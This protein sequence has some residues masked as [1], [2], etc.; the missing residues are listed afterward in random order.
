[1]L[2]GCASAREPMGTQR[3]RKTSHAG[4]IDPNKGARL[5]KDALARA[6][7]APR[8]KGAQ[9]AQRASEAHAATEWSART[10][11]VLHQLIDGTDE[12]LTVVDLDGRFTFV[13]PAALR[14]FGLSESECLG[15]P[16]F[17]FVFA[18]DR[19]RTQ[20]AFGDWVRRRLSASITFE[21]RQVGRGGEVRHLAWNILPLRSPGGELQGFA[22]FARDITEVRAAEAELQ[23]AESGLRAV[24]DTMLDALISIDLDGTIRSASESVERVL[25]YAR[26]EMIGQNIKILM[27]EP[28]RSAHDA[29]LANYRRTRKTWI[30]GQTRDF[31]VVK[32]DASRIVCSLAVSRTK[33]A[34]GEDEV[35]TGVFRDVTE[36]RRA[37]NALRESELRFH[38][39]FDHA[40]QYLGL[41]TPDGRMLEANQTALEATGVKREDVIGKYFWETRWWSHSK[42]SQALLKSA[43]QAASAGEF[44]RFE[45][46]HAGPEDSVIDVD[47]SIKPVKDAKGAVVLLIP[48]G[49][50]ITAIKRAQRT[51][52]AMLRAMATIGES[53]A[54][55]AH[56]IKNPIT[57]VNL[58][59]RAVADQ[60]GEDHKAI[61]EDL[62]LRMQRLEQLM[63]R[64]LSFA[65]PI[66][67]RLAKLDAKSLFGEVAGTLE[68]ELAKH[69]ADVSIDV[70]PS[71]LSFAGDRQLL[72]EVLS[73]LI[74]NALEAKENGAS[75]ILSARKEH[76]DVL[77]SV[78]DDGPGIPDSVRSTLFKPFTTTKRKGNGLGLAICKKIVEAHGGTISIDRGRM[79]GAR[80][81]LR[82]PINPCLKQP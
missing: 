1:M 45:T 53:A 63:K 7:R 69:G 44:V 6:G 42:E 50:D 31:E 46:V 30:I 23:R 28:Y 5:A 79:S 77:L 2:I 41:L 39:I 55:L 17:D 68:L 9:D 21:N 58:A 12:L 51:E 70:E 32:K 11:E 78:E 38:A 27:P 60:L 3:S 49:R 8:R 82:L 29:H 57:G 24:I 74:L 80:F 66:D 59:L 73:N 15:R 61:L 18:D 71:S 10:I 48:E 64:T 14:F 75:V 72:G 67:L 34:A 81:S 16:A 25:G 40:Y 47:F 36:Q 52:T 20:R 35:L 56:E 22:S 62:V 65:K 76:A 43:I 54:V 37:E 26:D 13:N 4:R 33:P 19:E